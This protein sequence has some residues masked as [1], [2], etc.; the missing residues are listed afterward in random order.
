MFWGHREKQNILR[1][2][3]QLVTRSKT[4]AAP[5]LPWEPEAARLRRGLFLQW[6]YLLLRHLLILLGVSE[7]TWPGHSQP[8]QG[9]QTSPSC[10]QSPAPLLKSEV[11]ST[12]R[13]SGLSLDT[14]V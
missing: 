5:L 14:N 6:N 12:L 10:T 1:L 3:S 4:P 7:G 13:S 9:R 8:G 2:K 11:A